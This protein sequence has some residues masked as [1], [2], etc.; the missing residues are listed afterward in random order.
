MSTKNKIVLKRN[1][2]KKAIESTPTMGGAA[3][4]LKLDWRTFKRIAEDHGLYK[5]SRGNQHST[6]FETEDIL[7]GIHP[8]YPTSKLSKRL[9]K[10]GYKKYKCEQCGI[11]NWNNEPIS[12]ELNHIDGDNGNHSLVNLELICPNC[13]S[14]TPTYRSKKLLLK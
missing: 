6:R 3:K 5:P 9:V 12:L 4:F 7:N 2:V 8:Q 10:E 1:E 14:Q 11:T 13:H